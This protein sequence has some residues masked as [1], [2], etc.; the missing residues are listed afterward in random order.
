M[1]K[2]SFY[3][4]EKKRDYFESCREIAL[5]SMCYGFL[6]CVCVPDITLG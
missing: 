3:K 5:D 4:K 6:N 2:S 1:Q